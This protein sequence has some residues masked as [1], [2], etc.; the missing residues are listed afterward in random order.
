MIELV[1]GIRGVC[2]PPSVGTEFVS[3]QSDEHLT[4]PAPLPTMR[5]GRTTRYC[6]GTLSDGW[7]VS[8]MEQVDIQDN[9]SKAA[10]D[11]R[12]PLI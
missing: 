6:P 3:Y 7:E 9:W 11:R 1:E 5:S 8:G 12:I 2:D 10:I 4:H